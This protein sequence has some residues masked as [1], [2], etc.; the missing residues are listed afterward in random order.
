MLGPERQQ[1]WDTGIDLTL[2]NRGGLSITYYDQTATDLIELVNVDLQS[3]PPTTQYQN[4]GR[5]RNTGVEIEGRLSLGVVGLRAGY[6]YARSRIEQ[7]QPG[8]TGD[9]QVGD[10][11]L[12]T[13]KHTANA[14]VSL[15]PSKATTL[16]AGLTYVGRWNNYDNLSMYGCFGGTQSCPATFP[17]S[18]R[19]FIVG[20][21]SIL[22]LNATLS[23]QI[24][25]S[26]SGFVSIDNLTNSRAYEADNLSPVMGRISTI[27]L[28]FRR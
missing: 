20:Y 13:P 16:S 21:P 5:V 24:S 11:T 3:S 15:G 26:I 14:G 7:L 8:Y 1:G 23:Q 12:L 27:G 22:K 25:S 17:A 18:T 19:S 4:V 10:Q 2:G 6:A 9:L 28:Q